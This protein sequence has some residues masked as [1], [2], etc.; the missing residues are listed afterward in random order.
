M[1]GGDPG[2]SQG[3]MPLLRRPVARIYALLLRK[4]C[5]CLQKR[6]AKSSAGFDGRCGRQRAALGDRPR[7]AA[8]RV[9]L[10]SRLLRNDAVRFACRVHVVCSCLQWYVLGGAFLARGPV[11]TRRKTHAPTH[12][13]IGLVS[14]GVGAPFDV[15]KTRLM[16]QQ[17]RSEYSGIVDCAVRTVKDEGVV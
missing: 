4:R 11:K 2:L 15:V 10:T 3:Q 8:F 17:G 1:Q 14:A 5:R 9:R 12:N 16:A 7:C 13:H 6:A